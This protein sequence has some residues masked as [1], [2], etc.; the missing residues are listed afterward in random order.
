[1]S[2]IK[3]TVQETEP[4]ATVILYGSYA[5]GEENEDSDIDVLVLLNKDAITLEE[6]R[7]VR[8]PL[9]DIE[10]QTGKIISPVILSRNDW[11]KIH[12]ITPFYENVNADGILL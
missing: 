6:D 11:N 1:M 10:F 7:S 2:R 3:K 9:Y 5:R 4:G 8:Y 12:N